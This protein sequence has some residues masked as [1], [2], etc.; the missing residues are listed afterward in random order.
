MIVFHLSER[1][2]GRCPRLVPRIPRDRLPLENGSIQRICVAP[3]IAGCLL[4][5]RG[6]YYNRGYWWVYVT[7]G[8][9]VEPI[10]VPD[11]Q[12]T[13]EVWFIRPMEFVACKRIMA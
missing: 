7:A 12:R 9:P 4:A 6:C 5:L 11:A 8:D 1:P 2:L 13:G 3:T 10:G